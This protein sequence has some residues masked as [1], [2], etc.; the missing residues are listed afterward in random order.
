MYFTAGVFPTVVIMSSQP[1]VLHV[2][3]G[4]ML[5]EAYWLCYNTTMHNKY[6]KHCTIHNTDTVAYTT[7]SG[8]YSTERKWRK[9]IG[10]TCGTQQLQQYKAFTAVHNTYMTQ[11]NLG[12][13]NIKMLQP[14]F[15]Y[16]FVSV[17]GTSTVLGVGG[18]K[19]REETL[20]LFFKTEQTLSTLLVPSTVEV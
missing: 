15:Q 9:Y 6:K 11:K 19:G 12:Y 4:D 14:W 3:R 8:N 20:C 10:Y 13:Q 16:Y 5:W 2:L 7:H 1:S 17:A 18:G